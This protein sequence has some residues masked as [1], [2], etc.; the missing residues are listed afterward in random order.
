MS[1]N[2][3]VTLATDAVRA[4]LA[5]SDGIESQA[6]TFVREQIAVIDVGAV[7]VDLDLSVTSWE[8]FFQ[9]IVKRSP[10]WITSPP[11]HPLPVRRCGRTDFG[12]MAVLITADA[13]RGKST[14]DIL[15]EFLNE[16]EHG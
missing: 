9:D 15:C 5:A 11:L 4:A 2:S 13:I 3:V 6:A 14:E 10:T 12:G 7:Y 8:C 16:A 1:P